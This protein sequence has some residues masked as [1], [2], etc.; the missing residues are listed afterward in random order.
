MFTFSFDVSKISDDDLAYLAGYVG[1]L[2]IEFWEDPPDLAEFFELIW[3]PVNLAAFLRRAN[4]E[5]PAIVIDLTNIF[6]G[7]DVAS[8]IA[9]H[10]MLVKM[11]ERPGTTLGAFADP[12]LELLETFDAEYD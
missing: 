7:M 12:L 6:T 5:A 9:V 10:G 2:L 3:Q 8:K 11:G 1:R 4:L